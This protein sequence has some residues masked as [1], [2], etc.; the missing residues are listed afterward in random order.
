MI[1]LVCA[2]CGCLTIQSKVGKG[3]C[4]YCLRMIARVCK[5]YKARK[6][7]TMRTL[8]KAGSDRFGKKVNDICKGIVDYVPL[9]KGEVDEKD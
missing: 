3:L 2:N 8:R 6:I 7:V 5:V 9:Q 1:V 4:N